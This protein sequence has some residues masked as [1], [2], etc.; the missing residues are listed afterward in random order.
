MDRSFERLN[1]ESRERLAR[2]V[3]TLTPTQLSI[4]IGEGWTVA[5]ALAHMG[6]WDRW[7]AD[8]WEEMLAGRWTADSDSILAAEHLANDA[9]HPYWAGAC[10]ADIPKLALEA[11]GRLD[12]L[13]ASVP[14]ETAEPLDGT[15]I[16]FLLHRHRHRGEHLD[17]IERSIA[18]AAT[19]DESYVER[20]AA[21]RRR[22]AAVVERL[23][24]EDM[25]LPT[26][27]E[28]GAWTVAQVLG[29]IAFWDRSLEA[30]WQIAREAAGPSGQLEPT[31]LPDGISEAVNRPLAELIGSW[32]ERLG[33]AVG[34]E[35][36]A[37]AESL[38]PII[39]ELAPRLPVG[40]ASVLPRVVNRWI[41]RDAHVDQIERALALGRPAAARVA[42]TGFRARNDASRARLAELVARVSSAD[43]ARSAGGGSWTV[44]VLFGHLAFWDRFL[45]ARWRAALASGA[46]QPVP[47]SHDVSDLLNDA[48]PASWAALAADAGTLGADTVAAAAEV[49]SIIG[50]LPAR[51]PF[52]EI[53]AE[54]PALLDRSLHRTEHLDDIARA[55]GR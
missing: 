29:H 9:L 18:A 17:H 33:A 24:V 47:V 20:N 55:L 40:T 6:F 50:S 54:R 31:Y 19:T 52:A 39:E 46:A 15:P 3:A 12:A 36:V 23:R 49:D 8:R 35:A 2:L 11:A 16:A 25:G 10:A 26:E 51:V 44:G 7:Q 37:A 43:L 22:L 21:S 48:L 13:I 38:D 28:E 30:R 34:I 53:L 32:T 42:D 41:H 4:G 1:D 27:T 14:D 45:A 5:S